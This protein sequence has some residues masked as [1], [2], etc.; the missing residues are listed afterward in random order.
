MAEKKDELLQSELGP[1]TEEIMEIWSEL[2]EKSEPAEE[3]GEE[4]KAAAE[5]KEQEEERSEA[6]AERE[7]PA[8]SKVEL[9]VN[10][11]LQVLPKKFHD[12]VNPVEGIR[13]LV[14]SYRDLE[15]RLTRASQELAAAT[16]M[17]EALGAQ[18]TTIAQEEIGRQVQAGKDV[19][20]QVLS[21][22][23]IDVPEE[24]IYNDLPSALKEI[25]TQAVNKAT[26]KVM[27]SYDP[28][29]EFQALLAQWEVAKAVENLRAK[30][31]QTFDLVKAD[32]LQVLRENPH[33]DNVAGLEV[34]YEKAKERYRQRQEQLRKQLLDEDF[35]KSL[36]EDILRQLAE[37][38]GNRARQTA[39]VPS[40][41]TG[42]GTA[43]VKKEEGQKKTPEEMMR[44]M[45]AS[46]V[47]TL[48]LGE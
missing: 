26:Q 27:G 35:V 7:V 15:A 24:K 37:Q 17:L 10:A 41:A 6:P 42:G 18:Q 34:A 4:K 5:S 31:P 16:R 32:L 36:R 43:E 40:A 44:D 14:E 33:L 22:D 3:E 9:D 30:D 21:P 13:K 19:V 20:N 8:E 47:S 46:A 12:K 25:V 38:I 1:S 45:I 28:S 2:G 29:L 11:L 23:E 48:P 39:G